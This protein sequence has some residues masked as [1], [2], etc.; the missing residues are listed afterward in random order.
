MKNKGKTKG[1]SLDPPYMHLLLAKR[2][3]M[4]AASRQTCPSLLIVCALCPDKFRVTHIPHK[5]ASK[6]VF[7][8]ISM[9]PDLDMQRRG[10]HLNG[11]Q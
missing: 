4:A 1:A 3:F 6:V 11:S 2:G 8:V 9:P 10:Y 5:C 7:T